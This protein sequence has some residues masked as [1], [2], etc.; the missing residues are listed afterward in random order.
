M[1]FLVGLGLG[2]EFVEACTFDIWC[3]IERNGICNQ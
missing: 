2:L 3:R 1:C